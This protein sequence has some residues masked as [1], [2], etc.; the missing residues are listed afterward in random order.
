[1]CK[2][3]LKHVRTV[4]LD[5]KN[6]KMTKYYTKQLTDSQEKLIK[7]AMQLRKQAQA[8]DKKATKDAEKASLLHAKANGI[9]DQV[10]RVNQM[11]R[12]FVAES[13]CL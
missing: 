10:K 5:A 7:K 3:F 9:F 13:S 11:C 8:L 2:R 6:Q 1:M 4:H 12:D